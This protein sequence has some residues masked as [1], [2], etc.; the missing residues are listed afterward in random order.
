MRSRMHSLKLQLSEMKEE[1][2][3]SELCLVLRASLEMREREVV[4]GVIRSLSLWRCKES[5]I[6]AKEGK[7][8]KTTAR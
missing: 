1:D 4:V 7:M 2:E 6:K 8:E 3:T 5:S